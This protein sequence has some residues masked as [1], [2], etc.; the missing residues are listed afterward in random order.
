M[1][2]RTMI[3]NSVL[4]EVDYEATMAAKLSIAKKIY[5]KEKG[6]VLSSAEFQKYFSENQVNVS[7]LFVSLLSLLVNSFSNSNIHFSWVT[8]MVKTLCSLLFPKGLFRNIGS[9]SVGPLFCFY[10]RQGDWMMELCSFTLVTR[11]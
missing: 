5:A 7:L 4:Q 8:G 11:F 2:L 3:L 10:S 9:Q 1:H 6:T